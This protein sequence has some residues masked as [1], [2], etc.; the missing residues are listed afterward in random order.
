M[1]SRKFYRTLILLVI[2]F[3]VVWALYS[4]FGTSKEAVKTGKPAPNFIGQ[5]LTGGTTE[6]RKLRGKG[7]VLNFWGT[8]CPP[9]RE[10][11]PALNQ[12]SKE[13]EHKGVEVVAIND[14]ESKLS[15]QGFAN[16]YHLSFPIVLDPSQDITMKY[17]I[18]PLPTTFFI[19][20][21]GTVYK[22]I[23]GGP[24]SIETI[25]NNMTQIEPSKNK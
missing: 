17:Q 24:M 1:I 12:A 25:R 7:V 20:P 3:A 15:V 16:Q 11:M 8:W 18:G 10:E 4:E 22:K 5:N 6:L 21:D 13:F 2:F 19:K 23:E 14:G 9:C